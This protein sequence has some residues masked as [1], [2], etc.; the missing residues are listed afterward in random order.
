[1]A[2]CGSG[3]R[4]EASQLLIIKAT[5]GVAQPLYRF[6]PEQPIKNP[7]TGS[8]NMFFQTRPDTVGITKKGAMTRILTTP[9]PQIG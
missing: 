8:M 1:M 9:W 6:G 3:S 5:L 2:I 4:R 7:F